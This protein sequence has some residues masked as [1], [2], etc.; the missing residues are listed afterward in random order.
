MEVNPFLVV[1]I[2]VV[3]FIAVAFVLAALHDY[4]YT[5]FLFFL[6]RTVGGCEDNLRRVF[7]DEHEVLRVHVRL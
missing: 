7:D 5:F 1:R 3:E 6:P 2:L 4:V